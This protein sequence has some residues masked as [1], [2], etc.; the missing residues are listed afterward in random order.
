ME[1][2]G[3]SRRW[4][5]DLG[6]NTDSIAARSCRP[7]PTA[8]EQGAPAACKPVHITNAAVTGDNVG[9]SPSVPAPAGWPAPDHQSSGRRSLEVYVYCL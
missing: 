7:G 3:T 9:P 1:S 5:A 4:C 8:D 6:P 2:R